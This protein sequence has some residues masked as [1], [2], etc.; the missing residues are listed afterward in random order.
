MAP[1]THTC[2]YTTL[3]HLALFYIP[4]IITVSFVVWMSLLVR[5]VEVGESSTHHLLIGGGYFLAL[6]FAESI[7]LAYL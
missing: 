1:L 4:A 2:S 7:L 3:H 6:L 5:S